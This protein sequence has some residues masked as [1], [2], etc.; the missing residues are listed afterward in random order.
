MKTLRL[1]NRILG[2]LV[3]LIAAIVYLLTLEPTTSFWDCGEFIA[4]AYKLQVGHPPGAPLFMIAARFFSLF[5]GGD[6]SKVAYMVNALSG[7]VSAFTILFL[8]WTI[9][10]LAV[11]VI[12]PEEKVK[13]WQY[14]AILGSALVGALTYTFSDTFW[15]SAV[16]GEVYASSSLFTALVFWAILKWENIAD[17]KYANRWLI[18]IAYLMG[19]SIGVHLL[20]L[21]AIPAIV[22]VF[23]FRKFRVTTRGVIS[24]LVLSGIMLGGLMYVII[25]GV[26][27]FAS[28][29]E[30][31]FVNGFGLPYN[32]G[33]L[34]YAAILI[35]GLIYGILYTHKRNKVI[36]NT[37]ILVIT[38]IILGYS[39]FSMI[40]IRSLA[41]PPMNENNPSTVFS[42]MYYLNR[43]QYGDR[44]LVTGQY[45][46]APRPTITEGKKTY[47]QRNGKYAVTNR[48]S[49]PS[50]D[51]QY[52]TVFPRMYSSNPDHV[53]VYLEWSGLSQ[54]DLYHPRYNEGGGIVTNKN[55]N[56]VY[57]TNKPK[58]KPSF[59]SNLKFFFTYQ[60]GHM[61]LR[62]FMWNFSGRQNDVQ[63]HGGPLNGN[64]I[65]GIPM[66]DKNIIGST[67]NMPDEIKNHPARNKYY[68]LPLIL[69]LIGL[70]SHL[71]KHKKDFSIVT[72]L[73]VLT[74][75]AVVVYLNQTPIQPRERDYAYAGSF[76][77]FAIWIG[78][79][80]LGIIDMIG[81]KAENA[82]VSVLVTLMCLVFVPSMMAMENWNDHN[83][84]GRY[85]ARDIAY[86]Y[87]NSCEPNSILFTGGD[88][89]TFPLW[90]AQEVEGIRTDVRI[91]NLMLLNMDWYIDQMKCK[92]YGSD[93]LPITMKPEQYTNGTRDAVYI[94]ERYK[95]A[96][97]AREI[98]QFIVSDLN[99]TKIAAQNGEFLNYAPTRNF[100]LPVDSAKVIEN[101]TVK[102]QNASEIVKQIEG[103][104]TGNY[105]TKS[106]L[107]A[108]D[109][110]A[111]N[112]WE[113]PVYFVGTNQT[114]E[115]GISDY[116][117]LDGLAYRFVPIKTAS[118]SSFEKGR[119]DT[120]ILYNKLMNEFKY[121]R[122]NKDDVTLDHFHLRTLSVIRLRFRFMRLAKALAS[123]G[124]FKKAEEVL[125]RIME[126]TPH[127]KIPYHLFIPGIVETYFRIN[128]FEKGK[129]ISNKMLDISDRYLTYYSTFEQKDQ[130]RIME[131]ITYHMR[132]IGNV[133]HIARQYNQ[134][135]IAITAEQ[136]FEKYN[137][138]W[139]IFR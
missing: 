21:L 65:T 42:L 107:A 118:G 88:N 64:W 67:E 49:V 25:P 128:Q 4:S 8:F 82:P 51:K 100:F 27:W 58:K 9:T 53:N 85:T 50:Y 86:D 114:D 13:P 59:G 40:V 116:V 97:D 20:N 131:E 125:D 72:M 26:I 34:F 33:V 55:G 28:K 124:D 77:A 115:F 134:T 111:N 89:D 7:L 117:Q 108:L 57:D 32:T 110:L 81:K 48:K 84:S 73:F 19:L 52:T 31:L 120:E 133:M 2:W 71:G 60:I 17:E 80:V 46:N 79:G 3:F 138:Q 16:E 6:V 74:G 102:P 30:L 95:Q 76:Y 70:F 94:Y 66:V 121:G 5:A 123:E 99:S 93:P 1:Y 132:V 47:T 56:I 119:I 96:F 101:G 44:P 83:R 43:E 113:R 41:N 104:I 75:I 24:A 12:K 109:F 39:S 11:K 10:H 18:F 136:L 112:N 15:F 129:T 90:Y 45:F 36:A 14:I 106:N 69:G 78:L 37:I 122:M 103:R 139:D 54:E 137:N 130:N 92:V 61:Y 105:L 63:G 87:L 23:Y 127:E 62:Y 35:G 126:L 29:F 135:D 68:L 91:V 98:V 38:V 22:L